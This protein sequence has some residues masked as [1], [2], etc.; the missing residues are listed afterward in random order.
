MAAPS[1]A[2]EED[3][4]RPT[5]GAAADAYLQAHCYNIA[6]IYHI[7]HA[8]DICNNSHSFIHYLNSHGMLWKEVEYL[9]GLVQS[10]NNI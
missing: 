4:S 7:E 8:I 2:E 3:E 9:W 5:F 6:A 1:L 10:D